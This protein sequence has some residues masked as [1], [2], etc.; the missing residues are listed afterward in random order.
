MEESTYKKENKT[1]KEE[2]LLSCFV[3][4]DYAE[5]HKPHGSSVIDKFWN[6]PIIRF[7]LLGQGITVCLLILV[8]TFESV[9]LNYGP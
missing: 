1:R 5:C 4:T 2:S 7:Q 8:L 3:A 6:S 9:L